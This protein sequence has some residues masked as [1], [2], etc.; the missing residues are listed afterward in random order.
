MIAGTVCYMSPEQAAGK[1]LDARTDIFS[2]GAVLYEMVTGRRPFAGDSTA[3]ILSAILRDEPKPAMDIAPG[4]PRDL[5]RIIAR[6]LQ[7]DPHRR[8]QHA[9]DLK[10]DLQ[11]VKEQPAFHGP[12]QEQAPG[13]PRT[14]QRRWLV[15]AAACV[16]ASFAAGWW[17]HGPQAPLPPWN[18][19]RLTT[20]S[21]LSGFAALSPDGKLLAYSADRGAYGERDLYV[22]QVAGGQP[23]RLTSDGEGNTTP[24]FSPDGSKIVFRSNRNGG[25][26][27]EIPAFGGDARL[28]ARDGLNPKYS[29]DGSQIAYWIGSDNVASVV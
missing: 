5:D 29:P 3:S 16:A 27:Y 25:G 19:T 2:F 9:G 20:D 17:L 6:C 11:E 4:V 15:A 7:K 10:L 22:K 28:L 26:L 24:D 14:R 13:R 1:K 12:V 18:V 8:Y 21:G 23:I